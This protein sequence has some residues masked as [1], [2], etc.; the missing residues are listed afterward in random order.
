MPSKVVWIELAKGRHRSNAFP[1]VNSSDPKMYS[2]VSAKKRFVFRN[3]GLAGGEGGGGGADG[4]GG[5]KGLAN[6]DCGTNDICACTPRLAPSP[7]CLI[8]WRC[9][10][11]V[12]KHPVF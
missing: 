9:T 10:A 5:G 2:W 7:F 11:Y 6:S 1:S 8:L 4:K 12:K 3:P